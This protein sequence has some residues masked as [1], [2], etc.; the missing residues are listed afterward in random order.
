M[1]AVVS[2]TVNGKDCA[3]VK[4]GEPVMMDMK[5]LLPEGAGRI[6][7]VRFAAEDPKEFPT[8]AD[9]KALNAYPY[10]SDF[11]V[12]EEDGLAGA[13]A[14]FA[15]IYDKPGTYFASVRVRSTRSGQDDD[16]FTQVRNIARVRIVVE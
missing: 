13:K 2:L 9:Q 5:A 12:I 16:T 4:V 1:Q 8:M 7:E 10:D 3:H 6:T 14:S 15:H 11:F